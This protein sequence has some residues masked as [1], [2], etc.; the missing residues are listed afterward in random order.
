MAIIKSQVYQFLFKEK[1][2]NTPNTKPIQ[3]E[4]R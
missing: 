2:I 4:I 1:P 3:E